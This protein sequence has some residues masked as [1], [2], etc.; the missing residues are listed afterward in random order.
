MKDAASVEL[1]PADLEIKEGR[2]HVVITSIRKLSRAP[3]HYCVLFDVSGSEEKDFQFQKS[4]GLTILT[5][6]IKPGI[7]HGWILL[8]N[9]EGRASSETTDPQANAN[10]ISQA[11]TLRRHE[12]L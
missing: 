11:G 8:F 6:G 5:R 12:S 1:T 4:E 7:D 9:T 10:L 3:L 2:K